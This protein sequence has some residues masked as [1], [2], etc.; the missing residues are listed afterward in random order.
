[1]ASDAFLT[2]FLVAAG[3]LVV[4]LILREFW[5][6]YWKQ[7]QQLAQLKRIGDALERLEARSPGYTGPLSAAASSPAPPK[8]WRDSLLDRMAGVP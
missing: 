3:V 1:M 6:W 5:T 8:G 4:F 2:V 7:S